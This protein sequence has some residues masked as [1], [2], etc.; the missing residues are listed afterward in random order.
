[1]KLTKTT[2]IC[3]LVLAQTISCAQPG[4]LDNTFGNNGIVVTDFGFNIERSDGMTIQNDGKILLVGRA[5]NGA[6]NDLILVR[7][8]S[9]GTLD[10]SF[11][12]DGI[13]SVDLGGDEFGTSVITSPDGKIY[14][15]G[16]RNES[17]NRDFLIYKFNA[18]GSVDMTFGTNGRVDIDFGG[19]DDVANNIMLTSAA[20]V[21]TGQSKNGANND[22]A[23][24]RYLQSDGTPDNTFGALGK[25]TFDIVDS[26]ACEASMLQESGKLTLFGYV[27]VAGNRDFAMV[28]YNEDGSLD[29]SFG[30]AGAKVTDINGG[31]DEGH[32]ITHQPDGKIVAAGIDLSVNSGIGHLVVVRHNEDGSLDGSFGTGGKVSEAIGLREFQSTSLV[33]MQADGKILIAGTSNVLGE[34]DE[35]TLVRLNSDGSFDNTFGND[36]IVITDI[37]GGSNLTKSIALQIDGKIVIGGYAFPDGSNSGDLA[38]CRYLSGTELGILDFSVEDNS[39]L[40]YPNP[41]QETTVLEY[42]LSTSETISIDLYDV[43]GRLV[44]SLVQSEKRTKGPQKETLAL[45]SYLPAGTYI[46]TL[47]TGAGSSS[48]RITK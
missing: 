22:F 44:Q 20:V 34:T 31:S 45:D 15:A 18:D 28:R 5:D 41:V 7:Y 36:G 39:M 33:A 47:S 43:S 17:P 21:V 10:A 12:G 30:S 9:D 26:D 25:V 38:M 14:V 6:N 40:V 4:G 11:D 46:L 29:N 32:S 1:M 24:V 37:P 27:S 19:T 16:Y 42:T 3:L 48:V 35:M 13:T 23:A 8:N 2:L